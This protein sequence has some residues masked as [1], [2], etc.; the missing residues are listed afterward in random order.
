MVMAV[1]YSL[2]NKKIFEDQPT[3]EFS[4]WLSDVYWRMVTGVPIGI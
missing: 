3:A 1:F 2:T 4:F